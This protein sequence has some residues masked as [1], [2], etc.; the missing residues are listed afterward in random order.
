MTWTGLVRFSF[1]YNCH[2]MPTIIWINILGH[3]KSLDLASPVKNAF[4][5]VFRIFCYI[6]HV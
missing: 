1:V 6:G 4:C 2:F 3:S 5:P